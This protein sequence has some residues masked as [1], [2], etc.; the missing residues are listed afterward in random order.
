MAH[1]RDLLTLRIPFKKSVAVATNVYY[2]GA[3][4]FDEVA[5]GF[6][7]SDTKKFQ[8]VNYLDLAP[9]NINKALP[10]GIRLQFDFY[11]SSNPFC[12]V[13]YNRYNPDAKKI[14]ENIVIN[15]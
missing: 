10:Q 7:L 14:M 13:D 1:I 12:L 4:N 11:R 8:V 15:I 2:D 3:I 5:K 9:Y 6:A